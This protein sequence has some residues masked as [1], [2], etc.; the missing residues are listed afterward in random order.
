MPK[1]KHNRPRMLCKQKIVLDYN[2]FGDALAKAEHGI[3]LIQ[4]A[5]TQIMNPDLLI[6]PLS[7][8]EA[9]VSS[10]IEGTVSTVSDV[11]LEDAGA[12]SENASDTKQVRNYRTAINLG[13]LA[14]KKKRKISPSLVR[15][16]HG[17]LLD[18]VR[19]KGVAG[20]FRNKTVYI[21]KNENDPIEKAIY[22][23]PE[24]M[25][26]VDYFDDIINFI[27]KSNLRPLLK[28]AIIHY[29]F[30]AVHPFEDGNGRIG[31]LLI[32]LMLMQLKAITSPI[33]YMSGQFEQHRDQYRT[34]LHKVDLTGDL[35]DW[36]KYF[37]ESLTEQLFETQ[38]VIQEIVGLS[39][40]LMREYE[41]LHTKSPTFV[42][43]IGYMFY[44]PYFT[45]PRL[46]RELKKSRPA[47]KNIVR[48]LEKDNFIKKT[49][50]KDVRAD[51]YE[52]T[53]LLKI[54]HDA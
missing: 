40:R 21:A 19:H 53:P 43:L 49:Q 30:E 31:R 20:K 41:S 25:L 37:L 34:E 24:H 15:E 44:S 2:V 6:S 1:T 38:K 47:I 26:V 4:I 52:F 8:K 12:I 35:N 45:I 42:P 23:P 46:Q 54:L 16:M 28:T 48:L 3:G 18:K 5:Q 9:E 50:V 36:I 11:F 14:I 10:S 7:T 13:H 22:I 33:I 29:Q 17:A 51:I 27:G 32:P 39:M